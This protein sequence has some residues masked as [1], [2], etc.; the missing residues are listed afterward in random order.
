MTVLQTLLQFLRSLLLRLN[1]A[2]EGT[3]NLG[4][5]LSVQ[6]WAVHYC[7]QICDF[8]FLAFVVLQAWPQQGRAQKEEEFFPCE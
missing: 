3:L 2:L 6:G 8:C 4:S 1:F 5:E 7:E